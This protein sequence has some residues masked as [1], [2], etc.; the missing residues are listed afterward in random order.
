MRKRR[1]QSSLKAFA[2]TVCMAIILYGCAS[3]KVEDHKSMSPQPPEQ[4]TIARITNISTEELVGKM[5]ITLEADSELTYTAFKLTDPLRLVL[6]LPGVNT[7]SLSETIFENRSP[8]MRITP[9]QFTDGGTTNSRIEVALSRLTPYQVFSDNNKL[10][11]DLEMPDGG[12]MQTG[13]AI[14]S[15]SLPPGF[16]ELTLA[17]TPEQPAM[18]VT[19][20]PEQTIQPVIEQPEQTTQPA[21]KQPEQ[22]TQPIIEQ[23]LSPTPAVPSSPSLQIEQPPHTIG[24]VSSL[25]G[26]LVATVQDIQMTEKDGTTR[27]II[28]ADRAPEFEMK[29][30]Q[31]GRLLN[32][33]LQQAELPPGGE[34]LLKPDEAATTVKH[35]RAFQLRRSPDGRENVVRVRVDLMKASKHHITTEAG[36]VI[37]DIEHP[38]VFAREELTGDEEMSEVPLVTGVESA[39]F[40]T[41]EEEPETALAA[42]PAIRAPKS[43]EEKEYKGQLISIHFQEADILDVLQ[44][45]SEVSGLNL[46]VHPNVSGQVTVHLTNVPWD[47]ALDIVLKMNN[48]SV[49]IDGN[50]L[51]VANASVFQNEI[52]ARIQ[53]QERQ[54]QARQVQ[55][56]LEPL[57]TKL[58]TL[59][60]ITTSQAVSIINQ[61][62]QGDNQNQEDRRGTITQDARTKTLI[63]QDTAENI[64]KI[65]EV[66][67]FLDRRTPQIMIEARV[68]S[69]DT[70]FRKEL[71]ISWSGSFSADPQHG[72][73]LDY[74]FPYSVDVPGFGVNLPDLS[75]SAI[76]TTGPITLGSIDD[77]LTVFA[78]IDAAEQEYK[79]KTLSQPKIFTQDAVPA[80]VN[81]TQTRQVEGTT[82][83]NPDT[84]T[85]TTTTRE[86]SATLSLSV[87]PRV[88]S[89]GYITMVVNLS[90]GAFTGPSGASVQQ[91][92]VN[93]QIT[94]KDGETA[95]IGGVYTTR[96]TENFTAVPYLHKI[97]FL[98]RLFK[99]KLPNESSQGELLVFLTPHILDRRTLKPEQE[100]TDISYSY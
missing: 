91:Q 7:A 96:E 62:F 59:N 49:E 56:R 28:S 76:G 39:L 2:W 98:G 45:I 16:E 13:P 44:V 22:T 33:D 94:V 69:I 26:G 18:Q 70:G 47:Q 38:A 46:V 12:D 36:K 97:P 11:I 3:T 48:L 80:S 100:G 84:G 32:L 86:V 27:I 83:V 31:Q 66:I 42:E 20:Q 95:V 8:L 79:A 67:S 90:N 34:K 30:T 85:V 87:T 9:F 5:R 50:I 10:F 64:K 54:L 19:S 53:Q 81:A 15:S 92:S 78:Q 35:V 77:V 89:D 1:S 57:E 99:S 61:Y 52:Q 14:A 24:G 74:R 63:I 73:A 75:G 68:V 88:S 37:L 40:G 51:R 25:P 29:A 65:E 82:T 72:N 23:P 60:F 41:D 55:E 43:G 4:Q 17:E 71:G 93:S 6:D 58:I 21:M